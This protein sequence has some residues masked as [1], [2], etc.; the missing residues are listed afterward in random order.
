MPS[1]YKLGGIIALPWEKKHWYAVTKI[2]GSYYDIDSK[3]DRVKLIGNEDKLRE[4]FEAI[5]KSKDKE[6][7]V[8]VHR[9]V[10]LAGT[11]RNN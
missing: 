4:Y 2:G 8:I 9:D 1:D 5:L 11:W 6:L 3:C 7:F 10:E